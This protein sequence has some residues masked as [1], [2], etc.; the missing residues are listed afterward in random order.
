MWDW[1]VAVLIGVLSAGWIVPLYLGASAYLAGF[2]HLLR[3]T[4]GENSFPYFSFGSGALRIG[5]VWCLVSAVY[6]TTY[7]AHRLLV[8]AR[9]K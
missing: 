9:T 8:S 2:E 4:E 5:A 6:W 1:I 3:G 7:G